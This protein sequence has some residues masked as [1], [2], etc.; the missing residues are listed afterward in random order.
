M[1]VTRRAKRRWYTKDRNAWMQ[2]VRAFWCTPQAVL[3]EQ[4]RGPLRY[5]GTTKGRI[6]WQ[7]PPQNILKPVTGLDPGPAEGDHAVFTAPPAPDKRD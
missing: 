1:K 2:W 6:E 4:T 3:S 7:G 5:A